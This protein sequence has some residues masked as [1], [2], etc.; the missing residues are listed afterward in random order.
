MSA[1]FSDLHGA[2]SSSCWLGEAAVRSEVGGAGRLRT[3]LAALPA[4]AVAACAAN[5]PLRTDY[6]LP[7]RDGR[8]P[9][10][11]P[12]RPPVARPV[13]PA[14]LPG[15]FRPDRELRICLPDSTNLPDADENGYVLD[16]TPWVQAPG[17]TVLALAPTPNACLTSG[18]GIRG[19]TVHKGID[20]QSRPPTT[21]YAAGPGIVREAEFR[22]DYGNMVVID[23]GRGDFT[24]YA[25]LANFAPGIAKGA[26]VGFGA[27]IGMMGGTA[28]TPVPIHLHYEI[29]TGAY[30]PPEYSF[31]LKAV[32]IF[33]LPRLDD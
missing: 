13:E 30:G 25:H 31:G 7:P 2:R 4:L 5:P 1:R 12:A 20:L 8:P 18:F 11:A 6:P 9:I 32:D 10:A 27:P 15:S 33:R 3:W 26:R 28:R 16:F 22:G 21:V 14:P 24:R 29:L 19:F 23:H 17:G